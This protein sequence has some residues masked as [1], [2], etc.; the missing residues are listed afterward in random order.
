MCCGS[1][2][3]VTPDGRRSGPTI[4]S[5]VARGDP[6]TVE[7][8]FPATGWRQSGRSAYNFGRGRGGN[9]VFAQPDCPLEPGRTSG[10]ALPPTAGVGDGEAGTR[11]AGETQEYDA[12]R[13]VDAFPPG[14]HCTT[15]H[16]TS[17]SRSPAVS[18]ILMSRAS[19]TSQIRA[20]LAVA[21]ALAGDGHEVLPPQ[22]LGLHHVEVVQLAP[23]WRWAGRGPPA[24]A[25]LEHGPTVGCP[26]RSR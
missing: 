6:P 23:G 9:G 11:G 17:G 22:V 4:K 2:W 3:R 18:E 19:A 16:A 21:G 24:P 5:R 8:G 20:K 15:D 13:Q 26:P 7:P 25:E 10:E 12:E 14:G 1:G